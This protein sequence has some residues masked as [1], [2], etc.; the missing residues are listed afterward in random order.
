MLTFM[1]RIKPLTKLPVLYILLIIS[2][3]V[4]S[5]GC[6]EKRRRPSRYVFQND[7]VGWVRV[8]FN[9]K[10]APSLPVEDGFYLYQV[11]A[12]GYLET[13]TE[14]EYGS[15]KDEYYYDSAGIHR[16]LESTG[17]GHGGMIW[18]GYNSGRDEK[19]RA[20]MYFFVGTEDKYKRDGVNVLRDA[21]NNP[22]VGPLNKLAIEK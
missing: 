21:L 8:D 15:A 19:G 22:Q 1:L 6:Q 14:I 9:V 3:I 16:R 4:I 11:P 2:G 12:S 5:A 18:A 20:Y 7:Y 17:W 13:S 10:S